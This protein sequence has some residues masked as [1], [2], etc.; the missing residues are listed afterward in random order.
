MNFTKKSDEVMGIP[1]LAIVPSQ[2]P[3]PGIFPFEI[4]VI[5]E[6]K[7]GFQQLCV[8]INQS[9]SNINKKFYR[10]ESLLIALSYALKTVCNSRQ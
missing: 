9:N 5:N 10:T 8:N 2:K 1:K 3:L 4:I 7:T 6:T